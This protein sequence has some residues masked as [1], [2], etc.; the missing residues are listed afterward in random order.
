[1]MEKVGDSILYIIREIQEV[2]KP[3]SIKTSFRNFHLMRSNAF[4]K[5]IL[6]AKPPYFLFIIRIVWIASYITIILS[7]AYLP[8]IKLL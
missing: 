5:S 8:G 4:S 1:M 7:A 3:I 6:I 2:G